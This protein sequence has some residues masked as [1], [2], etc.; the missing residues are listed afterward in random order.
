MFKK[1]SVFLV[2]LA[3]FN[4]AVIAEE[5]YW[6]KI[7]EFD[8]RRENLKSIGAREKISSEQI[9]Y[10][11]S[12]DANQLLI[13]GRQFW[14]YCEINRPGSSEGVFNDGPSELIYIVRQYPKKDG[15]IKLEPLFRELKD[16]NRN[17]F[18]RTTLLLFMREE[19]WLE[20]LNAGQIYSAI[21]GMFVMVSDRN[22]HQ[23]LRYEASETA[24]KLLEQLEK[25]NLLAEPIIRKKL[26]NGEQLKHLRKE[27]VDGK[28][29]LSD[30]YKQ[31]QKK[32][33][34][35]YDNYAQVLLTVLNE[36]E[37]KPILQRG[38]LRG[39]KF[40]LKQK[41]EHTVQVRNALEDAVRNYNKFDKEY[42]S[43]L[44]RIGKEDLNLPDSNNIAQKMLNDL[45][46]ELNVVEDKGKR[47]RIQS[48]INSLK[49][50]RGGFE[51]Q[52]EPK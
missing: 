6:L 48:E 11:N 39:L 17:V 13:S 24:K 47:S 41:I 40:S 16:T 15:L 27:V 32:T 5:N 29:T 25:N 44:V 50:I 34:E 1:L 23:R 7:K 8:E 49:R 37:L 12:L 52:K 30:N 33:I 14:E 21:D 4:S 51:K 45:Q 22:E 3:G 46:N 31:S 38:A 18:W 20:V 36:L 2:F 19:N 43:Y 26:Q 28:I 42:W 35:Y 10:I 9:A